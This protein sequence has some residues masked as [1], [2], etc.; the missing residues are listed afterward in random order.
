M[1][2]KLRCSSATLGKHILGEGHGLGADGGGGGGAASPS[3][4]I[5][6]GHDVKQDDIFFSPRSGTKLCGA[7]ED[8]NWC[9]SNKITV[10]LVHNTIT[11]FTTLVLSAV[12]CCLT[13]GRVGLP[14]PSLTKQRVFPHKRRSTIVMYL[15]CI[16]YSLLSGPTYAQHIFEGKGKVR[17]RTCHEGPEGS[18]GIALLFL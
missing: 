7:Q 8:I 2:M 17:P 14:E 15:P 1:S 10:K 3:S 13:T 18:R 12:L 6:R 4:R 5:K 9:Q 11:Y 16:L